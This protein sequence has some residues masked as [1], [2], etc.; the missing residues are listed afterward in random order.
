M[1]LVELTRFP[2]RIT[3]EIARSRLAADGIGAVLFDEGLAALGL[4]MLSSIRLM[5]DEG[6]RRAAAVSLGI[7]RPGG[8]DRGSG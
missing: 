1:A 8:P 6:D 3:A 4:Q 2:D 5:V 7:A